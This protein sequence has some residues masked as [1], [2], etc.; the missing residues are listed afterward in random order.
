MDDFCL[1]FHAGVGTKNFKNRANFYKVGAYV[2][3]ES[4]KFKY[5]FFKNYYETF[6]ED[7][8][9]KEKEENENKSKRKVAKV[10]EPKMLKG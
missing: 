9:N 1:D 3:N 8:L 2:E 4:D 6:L 10:K 7:R 5:E